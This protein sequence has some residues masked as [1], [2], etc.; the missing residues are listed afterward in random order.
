MAKQT[1]TQAND[2]F[3]MDMRAKGCE[4][5]FANELPH[6]ANTRNCGLILARVGNL[7]HIK[8]EA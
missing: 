2:Q 4:T 1:N 3:M 6:P 5:I 7:I 8:S